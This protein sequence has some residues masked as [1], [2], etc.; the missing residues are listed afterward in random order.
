MA[1][2]KKKGKGLRCN[3]CEDVEMNDI[4]LLQC[5]N[6]GAEG[7]DSDLCDNCN[8]ELEKV[9]LLQCPECGNTIDEKSLRDKWEL[10]KQ[11]KK[12]K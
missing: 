8:S 5:P 10:K 6:C 11:F 4:H 1:R 7:Y 12:L 3:L 2:L 9:P